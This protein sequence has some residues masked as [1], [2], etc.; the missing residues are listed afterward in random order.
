MALLPLSQRTWRLCHVHPQL[1]M[2]IYVLLLCLPACSSKLGG[3][4]CLAPIRV[5]VSAG[6]FMMSPGPSGTQHFLWSASPPPHFVLLYF[7]FLTLN[8]CLSYSHLK[9]RGIKTKGFNSSLCRFLFICLFDSLLFS[10]YT[11]M[12]LERIVYSL[13]LT[14]HFFS[15][16]LKSGFCFHYSLKCTSWKSLVPWLPNLVASL[17]LVYLTFL[18]H[19]MLTASFFMNSFPCFLGCCCPDF[20]TSSTFF[21]VAPL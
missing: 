3:R 20:P 14:F 5:T 6:A 12:Y 15:G 13:L 19:Y 2:L 8:P 18:R 4:K 10:W 1:S 11:T 9:Q 7:S 17:G 16:P 21:S